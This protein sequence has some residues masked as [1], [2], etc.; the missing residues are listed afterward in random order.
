[1][2]HGH[3]VLNLLQDQ[4][5]TLGELLQAIVEKY[6]AEETFYTCHSEGL[7][8][9]E[10]I[11]FFLQRGKIRLVAGGCHH[12]HGEEHD[13]EHHCC[14]GAGHQ[15]EEGHHCCHEKQQNGEPRNLQ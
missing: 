11:V 4:A 1:M 15:H 9:E 5:W 6:G 2:T 10:L 8:A 14:H 13:G 12:D 7:T 3:D